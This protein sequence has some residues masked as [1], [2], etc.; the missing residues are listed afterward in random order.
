MWVVLFAKKNKTKLVTFR[1]LFIERV[2]S[3]CFKCI[4]EEGL[5]NTSTTKK[6]LL[7]KH[8]FAI[9]HKTINSKQK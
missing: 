1:R 6:S 4:F 3:K 8:K 9:I 5:Y 2:H 7:K